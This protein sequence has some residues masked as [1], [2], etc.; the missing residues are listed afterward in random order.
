MM[1]SIFPYLL[2]YQQCAP[3]LLR[4]T[5]GAIFLYWAYKN[6]SVKGEKRNIYKVIIET[7]VGVLLVIGLFTQV[8][9]L[10]ATIVFVVHIVTKIKKKQFLSDG[11]NYY[12]ILLVISISL[13]LMGP[14]RLAFDLPL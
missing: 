12:L 10:V 11:I 6:F 8:A 1:L 9:A 7:V 3:L 4:L 2:S 14:G 5:L 13:I